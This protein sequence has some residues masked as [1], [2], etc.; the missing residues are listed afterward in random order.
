MAFVTTSAEFTFVH[1]VASMTIDASP[2]GA[3]IA[4]QGFVMA[5]IAVDFGMFMPEPEIRIIVIEAPDQPG[6]RVV[7]LR[8]FI[9]QG[10]LMDV[11]FTMTVDAF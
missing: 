6:V 1:V 11:V 2:V 10:A 3:N 9:A 4:V 8:A 7:A 5:T